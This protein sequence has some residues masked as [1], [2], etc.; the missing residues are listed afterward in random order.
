MSGLEIRLGEVAIAVRQLTDRYCV[1]LSE[2][3]NVSLKKRAI[4][5]G[6]GKYKKW[7]PTA[8]QRACYG[9]GFVAACP[10]NRLRLHGTD[11]SVCEEHC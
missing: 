1:R 8:V 5:R 3:L 9:R 10:R 2:V 6:K 4:V 7:L 11:V